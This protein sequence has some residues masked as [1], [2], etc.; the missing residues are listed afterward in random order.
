[1]AWRFWVDFHTANRG[2]ADGLGVARGG[3]GLLLGFGSQGLLRGLALLLFFGPLPLAGLLF[4]AA[5]GGQSR[6]YGGFSCV[7]L[8]VK[9]R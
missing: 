8:R 2:R 7:T 3:L 9:R 4:A 5:L 6:L 1:M